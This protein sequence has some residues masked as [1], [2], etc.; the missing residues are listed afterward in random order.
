MH[1]REPITIESNILPPLKE[2][3]EQY[4]SSSLTMQSILGLVQVCLC[5]DLL[6]NSNLNKSIFSS[7]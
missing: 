2:M 4:V 3:Q 7:L 6:G 5:G 1:L